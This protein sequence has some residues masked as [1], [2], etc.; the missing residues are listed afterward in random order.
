[1]WTQYGNFSNDLTCRLLKRGFCDLP[2]SFEVPFCFVFWSFD[3]IS[4]LRPC[5]VLWTEAFAHNS[6][7]APK[8]RRGSD[9]FDTGAAGQEVLKCSVMW[10]FSWTVIEWGGAGLQ[11]WGICTQWSVR[12]AWHIFFPWGGRRWGGVEELNLTHL[13][14]SNLRQNIKKLSSHSLG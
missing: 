10:T 13:H 1:M 12:L 4:P 5:A 3:I 11:R 9:P 8:T 7:S 6:T 14:F 2:K